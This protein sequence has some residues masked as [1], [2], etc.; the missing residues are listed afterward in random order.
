M[1]SSCPRD[2]ARFDAFMRLVE[3]T[4]AMMLG[5]LPCPALQ[6]QTGNL[7]R[8]NQHYHDTEI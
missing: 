8:R 7:L 1:L 3:V 6:V 4:G 5:V 2:Y